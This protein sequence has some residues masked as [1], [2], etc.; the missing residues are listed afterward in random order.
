M[1]GLG[2]RLRGRALAP[3]GAFGAACF[4]ALAVGAEAD[5]AA[6]ASRA[7]RLR[8]ANAGVAAERE[9]ALLELYALDARLARAEERVRA[10]RSEASRV[11]RRRV[12]ARANLRLVRETLRD[13]QLRLEERLRELY[14]EGDPDPLAVLLGAQTLGDAIDALDGFERLA[15]QDRAILTQVREARKEVEDAV[16]SLA[17]QV[18][19]LDRL[20]AEAEGARDALARAR[21]DRSDYLER[22]RRVERLNDATI[23]KLSAEAQAA[24]SKAAD[25]SAS[26]PSSGDDASPPAPP[27]LVT[28]PPGAREMT[29]VA[30]GYSLPGRTSTGIPV[31]WG[32]VAVDPAVIPLGTRMTIPGYGAGVAADTGPAVRGAVIDLWFPSTAQ[33]AAWGRRTVTITLR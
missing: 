23:A 33:S 22:L 3:A 27:P 17:G 20:V 15:R 25:L 10:L 6:S 11:E 18:A 5:D 4:L 1:R 29:V 24:E 8:N 30:T 32:V 7:D 21:A 12:S 16:R 14:V 31:G 9:R 19:R 13:A 2:D 28:G 26:P